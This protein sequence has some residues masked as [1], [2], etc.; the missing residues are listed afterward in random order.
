MFSG[1]QYSELVLTL[2][3][4]FFGLKAVRLWLLLVR[5]VFPKALIKARSVASE[6]LFALFQV[7]LVSG[8]GFGDRTIH[9]GFRS[10]SAVIG[11]S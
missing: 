6:K 11:F 3:G 7:L 8:Y 1:S 4:L 5:S 2:L 9:D 10:I